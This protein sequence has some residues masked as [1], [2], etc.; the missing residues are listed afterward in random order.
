MHWIYLI[1]EFHNL[2][3]VTEINELFQDILIYWDA[4][5]TGTQDTFVDFLY[6]SSGP[7]L[8]L[9]RDGY[10]LHFIDTDTDTGTYRYHQYYLV[11]KD[12]M[13]KAVENVKL[14]Y[15]CSTLQSTNTK[16]QPWC[17]VPS[18]TDIGIAIY[19][20]THL[21]WQNE[22]ILAKLNMN[23]LLF[24]L[25]PL[26]IRVRKLAFWVAFVHPVMPATICHYNRRSLQ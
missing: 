5:D 24:R 13:W 15:F 18:L 9:P 6:S 21:T 23:G 14:F 17:C 11:Q 3:W 8:G 4:Q 19:R 7:C 16:V 12:M 22:I 10:C 1:Q 25:K 20:Q 2:S 26:F